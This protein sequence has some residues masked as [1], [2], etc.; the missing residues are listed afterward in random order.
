MDIPP[1][2]PVERG[3]KEVS[4]SNPVFYK[5]GYSLPPYALV[6]FESV[7]ESFQAGP[8]IGCYALGTSFLCWPNGL[9]GTLVP[10]SSF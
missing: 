8:S 10:L 1:S 6:I 2:R 4:I 3:R 9:V 5:R 7:I